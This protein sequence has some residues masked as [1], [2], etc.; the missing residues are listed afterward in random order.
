MICPLRLLAVNVNWNEQQ[1]IELFPKNIFKIIDKVIPTGRDCYRKEPNMPNDCIVRW[2]NGKKSFL[3]IPSMTE[4]PCDGKMLE[5]NEIRLIPGTNIKLEI[6]DGELKIDDK[7]VN[8][9]VWEDDLTIMNAMN[10]ML[11]P[12]ASEVYPSFVLSSQSNAFYE[13]FTVKE[14][15]IDGA[16]RFEQVCHF[17]LPIFGSAYTIHCTTHDG[18]FITGNGQNLFLVEART[19][20]IISTIA[21]NKDDIYTDVIILPTMTRDLEN[22]FATISPI[23]LELISPLVNIIVNYLA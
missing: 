23:L 12:L 3:H 21:L 15:T 16:L 18:H 10:G 20:N 5:E 8:M 22:A 4:R 13:I 1:I 11:P 19:G 7:I 17:Y 6:V 2:S 9:P 14:D